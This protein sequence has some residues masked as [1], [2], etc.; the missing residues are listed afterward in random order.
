[1]KGAVLLRREERRKLFMLAAIG[2]VAG[3]PW[4]IGFATLVRWLIEAL[5]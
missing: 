4:W 1:M 3:V 2:V 5:R